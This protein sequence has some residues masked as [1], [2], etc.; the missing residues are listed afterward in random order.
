MAS[1]ITEVWLRQNACVTCLAR[2]DLDLFYTHPA[3]GSKA[4]VFVHGDPFDVRMQ[5][6]GCHTV[7]QLP[8]HFATG[9]AAYLKLVRQ[10][11]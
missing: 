7:K 11:L 5:S 3:A 2:L 9:G 4:P 1:E 10:Q 8:S 6:R